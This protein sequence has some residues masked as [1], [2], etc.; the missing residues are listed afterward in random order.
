MPFD[1]VASIHHPMQI[2]NEMMRDMLTSIMGDSALK[3]A[4]ASIPQGGQEPHVVIVESG[5]LLSPG[6]PKDGYDE[7]ELTLSLLHIVKC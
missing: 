1:L 2:M 6:E 3:K 5:F 4:L 7:G